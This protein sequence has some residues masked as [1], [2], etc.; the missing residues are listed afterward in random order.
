MNTSP[1]HEGTYGG[2][3]IKGRGVRLLHPM[4]TYQRLIQHCERI[5]NFSGYI[6]LQAQVTPEN[7]TEYSYAALLVTENGAGIKAEGLRAIAIILQKIV[8]VMVSSEEVEYNTFIH[9][10]LV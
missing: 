10:F 4:L 2:V 5:F 8:F 6:Q 1:N 3:S 7:V 9:L